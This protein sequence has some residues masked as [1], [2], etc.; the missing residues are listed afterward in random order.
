MQ[1]SQIVLFPLL[2]SLVTLS[3]YGGTYVEFTVKGLANPGS[4]SGI[5]GKMK[6]W[7]QDGNT[8]SQMQMNLL[9]GSERIPGFSGMGNMVMLLLNEQPDKT[10]IL[11]EKDKTYFEM[12]KR[13][14]REEQEN[15][16]EDFDIT[17]IGNEKING[18]NCTRIRAS[19]KKGGPKAE[20]EWWISREVPGYLEMKNFR[21]RQF[22][23]KSMYKAL[24]EKGVEGFPVKIWTTSPGRGRSMAMELELVKAEV[25]DI[26]ESR[27][28]L[29]GYTKKESSP[30]MSGG[31][32]PEKIK[33]MSPE[34]RMKFFQ[35]M[36]KMQGIPKGDGE[37]KTEKE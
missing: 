29:A 18:Y 24:Q 3:S 37:E 25:M 13:P 28:S 6:A 36:Q 9:A 11:N 1:K 31:M 34:E 22:N 19:R 32:D 30:F 10:Y 35:E 17:I 27:F 12:P 15:Q 16:E 26:P 23:T 21:T 14:G 4:E 20:M 7:Y 33:N 8:R 5:T 2:I